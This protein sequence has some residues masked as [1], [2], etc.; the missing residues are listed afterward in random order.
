MN[1]KQFNYVKKNFR[2]IGTHTKN[3]LLPSTQNCA[4]TNMA[5]YLLYCQCCVRK[6]LWASNLWP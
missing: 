5:P 2:R 3:R 1:I 6:D 4:N